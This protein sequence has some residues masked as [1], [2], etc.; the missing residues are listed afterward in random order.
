MSLW[1]TIASGV[2]EARTWF[3]SISIRRSSSL[4]LSCLTVAASRFSEAL[5]SSFTASSRVLGFLAPSSPAPSFPPASSSVA[6]AEDMVAAERFLERRSSSSLVEA[7]DSPENLESLAKFA[8]S[9][10]R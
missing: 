2:L 1:D 4:A 10:V 5:R 9:R 3:A 7:E 8:S 6:A